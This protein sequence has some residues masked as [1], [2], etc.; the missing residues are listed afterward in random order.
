[1][2]GFNHP[3]RDLARRASIGALGVLAWFAGLPLA[4]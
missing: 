4:R 3:D 2:E 1:M